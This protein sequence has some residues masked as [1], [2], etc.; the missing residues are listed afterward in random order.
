MAQQL[1]LDLYSPEQY[2]PEAFVA[3][4]SNGRAW[5]AVQAPQGWISNAL[6]IIGPEG[7]GKTHLAHVFAD[8]HQAVWL[9]PSDPDRPDFER[10]RGRPVVL[11]NAD[12]ADPETLFHLIN[13]SQS[14][15]GR[16]LLTA[17]DH[18][19][20]WPSPISDLRS[21]LNA[22]QVIDLD[23]PDDGLL[24]VILERLFAQR[25]IRPSSE[26]LAYLAN[27]IERSV[28]AARTIVTD[29]DEKSDGR[30]ITRHL[31]RMIL[32]NRDE[33]LQGDLDFDNDDAA[34]TDPDG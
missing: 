22:L 30:G 13:L 12:Q 27:R 3:S 9:E 32:D 19:V 10:L 4:V 33:A 18:P 16:L 26:L 11:D 29:L 23:K 34:V 31:A 15:G 21:R 7:T 2:N 24:R 5:D 14:D 1:R 8:R 28:P 17:R 6:A 20:S 25:A